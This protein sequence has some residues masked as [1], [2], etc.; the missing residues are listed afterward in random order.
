MYK[1]IPSC[2]FTEDSFCASGSTAT[3]LSIF[4][5]LPNQR[6]LTLLDV[7]QST[8]NSGWDLDR[9]SCTRVN[10]LVNKGEQKHPNSSSISWTRW[11]HIFFPRH[12]SPDVGY[13]A[14]HVT[15]HFCARAIC[16]GKLSPNC[17]RKSSPTF[18]CLLR[19]PEGMFIAISAFS[20]FRVATLWLTTWIFRPHLAPVAVGL[21]QGCF[22]CIHWFQIQNFFM[23]FGLDVFASNWSTILVLHYVFRLHGLAKISNV[24]IEGTCFEIEDIQATKMQ[25]DREKDTETN[26]ERDRFTRKR[27]SIFRTVES[28]F[29]HCWGHV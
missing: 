26:R 10:T 18:S 12:S 8:T 4:C 25:I 15:E 23:T 13:R 14:C 9:D 28:L 3:R 20:A 21:V 29:S 27:C 16:S 5:A 1:D 22:V 17:R 2:F 24:S 7:D 11:Y 19:S 6:C